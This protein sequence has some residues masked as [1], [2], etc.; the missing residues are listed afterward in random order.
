MLT[1]LLD[2]LKGKSACHLAFDVKL[3][4][5]VS[6]GHLCSKEELET[7]MAWA[8]FLLERERL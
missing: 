7:S 8:P 6:F 2:R 3:L 1:C 4:D 5:N